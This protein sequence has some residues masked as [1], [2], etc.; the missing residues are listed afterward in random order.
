MVS[1]FLGDEPD[2]LLV[3]D[4][5]RAANLLELVVMVTAEGDELVI[6]AMRMRAKYERLLSDD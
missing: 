6:H 3:I 2:R 4:P 1:V 5:S